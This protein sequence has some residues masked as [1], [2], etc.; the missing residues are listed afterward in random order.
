MARFKG[1][2]EATTALGYGTIMD[3]KSFRH[4]G[5][6]TDTGHIV[7]LPIMYELDGNWYNMR[8]NNTKELIIQIANKESAIKDMDKWQ[9]DPLDEDAAHVIERSNFDGKTH[10]YDDVGEYR[11]I[12]YD[13]DQHILIH[14]KLGTPV[15]LGQKL[16]SNRLSW[17]SS[18]AATENEARAKLDILVRSTLKTLRGI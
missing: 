16:H 6:E 18:F 15:A 9:G 17:L 11:N 14:A 8:D 4:G 2:N 13:P 3:Y 7:W 12:L 5:G 10:N 1:I